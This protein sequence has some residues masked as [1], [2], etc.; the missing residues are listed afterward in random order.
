MCGPGCDP[1][2]WVCGDERVHVACWNHDRA[3][4]PKTLGSFLGVPIPN[5]DWPVCMTE[6]A[7]YSALI[8]VDTGAGSLC[9]N[10]WWSDYWTSP[11]FGLWTSVPGYW[12]TYK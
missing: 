12:Q 11:P 4:C 1:W 5:L 3:Y 2:F 8:G 7:A 6:Y 9:S 10:D